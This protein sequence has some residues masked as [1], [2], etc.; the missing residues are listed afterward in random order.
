MMRLSFKTAA[1]IAWRETRSSMT[2]FV[3]VV[4]AVAAGVG[5]LAGVQ[6]FSQSFR[7]TLTD[8]SRTVMAADLTARQFMPA[9]D[10]QI[11]RLDALAGR[12]VEHTL[13]TETISMASSAMVPIDS[14]EA[15]PA[16]VS[17]KA[18]DPDKYPYYGQVKLDP[19]MPLR[20]AL[21]EDTVAVANDV[22]VRL[23]VQVG[24]KLRIG[25]QT[26]RISAVVVT[27]PDRMSG[28]MNVGLRMMMSREAFERTGLMG[29]GSRGAYRYLFKMSPTAPQVAAVR[30][31]LRRTLPD[32]L[33]ADFRQSNP[34][35]TRGLDR[36]TTFLSLV[37]LIAMIVGALGVAMAMHAH[38]QQK[39]DN[40]AVLK[41]LGAT[42]RDVIGIYTIQTLLLGIAGGIIGIAVGKA[43]ERT[44]PFLI[45]RYF[46]Q[47]KF[48]MGWNVDAAVQGIAVG[49]LT[50]L[51][52]TLPP[53]LAI[54]K[55]RPALILR[56]D[57][58]DAR[59]TW[60]K[61]LAET[62][63]S[64]AAGGLILAGIAAIA[65]W[66]AESPRVGGYFAGG[67]LVSLILLSAVASV[68]LRGVKMF[69]QRSPWRVPTLMRQGF[70]NLY[71]QGNQARAIMVAMGLGVMFTLTV[72]LVQ[73]SLVAEIIQSA[74]P[75]MPNV[76]LIG[77]TP[78]QVAPIQ[79]LIAQTK[80]V[81]GTPEFAPSV[82][83]RIAAVNGTPLEQ[84]N[85]PTTGRR[86]RGGRSVMF[87][88]EK[89][90]SLGIVSGQWWKKGETQP[91][92]SIDEEAARTLDI[93]VGDRIQIEALDKAVEA[94]V[95]A[96]H[97]IEQMRA[98][99]ANEFVFNP[100]ALEGLPATF[101]GGLRMKSANV[102]AFERAA[103]RQ[104]PTVTVVN[105]AEALA[106]VQQV[107]DQ[108]AIVIRF[109][110]AFAILAGAI[111][112]SASVAGTRFRRVKEVVILK[113]LGATRRNAGRI[114]S[115]EFL[116]LGAVAGLMGSLLASVF[117]GLVLNRLL[118]ASY[119]FHWQAM[120]AAVVLT[121]LLAQA[122]GWLASFRI[123]KQK[124]LEVLRDE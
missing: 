80:G 107:V 74:P 6:G 115:V 90:A 118:D 30:E 41:S 59:L 19:P 119:S 60:R 77:I 22:L 99:A 14:E 116:T 67:L 105:V 15:T 18:V 43:I 1:R 51:L 47:I 53:L 48:T 111:I 24:E 44:F 38:L 109:L 33:V 50:T 45:D 78:E 76:F 65:G 3:F 64:L 66:L 75:G 39:M 79:A 124:P 35:I 110:S 25:K 62:R 37:S 83:V 86:F 31:E 32:A 95:M 101:Y 7:A 26:V 112:L 46:S 102:G 87:A 8:E 68:L 52:F 56:R 11:A 71:R 96:I 89:P 88:D 21:A 40:I 58:P 100:P 81:E 13:I 69:V 113:T 92:V 42:S 85:L 20:E 106:I 10:E 5:A 49:A 29:F 120:L 93:K 82:A 94:R 23:G 114:F 63:S 103:Y 108:V 72:Y 97:R 117:A 70:A 27:E 2:K 28:S 121:A 12:G 36:A 34:I 84:L 55:V 57:M 17:V 98:G 104:F 91:V 122:S 54:R 4:L 16:L 9:T 73:H 61:H 123:L